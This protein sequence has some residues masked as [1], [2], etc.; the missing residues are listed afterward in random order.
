MPGYEKVNW[1]RVK[2]RNVNWKKIDTSR[3]RKRIIAESNG[4][5]A[6]GGIIGGVV[7]GVIFILILLII[8]KLITKRRRQQAPQV[9]NI[10][11]EQKA[12]PTQNTVAPM[13]M[14]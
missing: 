5:T 3:E 7:G 12:P 2:L 1:T 10:T 9:T 4:T 14:G 8:Y 13:Q 11:I 6:V